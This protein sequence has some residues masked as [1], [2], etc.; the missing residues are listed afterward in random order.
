MNLQQYNAL[1]GDTKLA[2][3]LA[4]ACGWY[5]HENLGI[6]YVFHPRGTIGEVGLI[7]NPFTDASIPYGLIGRGV[8]FVK[9][10][11]GFFV[12][13]SDSGESFKVA[14]FKSKTHAIVQAYIAADVNGH[15]ARFLNEA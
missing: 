5:V 4:I 8:H 15:L 12:A 14:T 11:C 2:A 1:T 3:A 9:Y 7:F 10:T 13:H 6:I